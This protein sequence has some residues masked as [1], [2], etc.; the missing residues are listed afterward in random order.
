MSANL[1]FFP[2]SPRSQGNQ[3]RCNMRMTGRPPEKKKR[4]KEI[5][6][7]GFVGGSCL[8]TKQNLY[9]IFF[10]Q[11]PERLGGRKVLLQK[12]FN[13]VWS[14][15]RHVKRVL[16][17]LPL[18]LILHNKT[19][20][21]KCQCLTIEKSQGHA[22]IMKRIWTKVYIL[23]GNNINF[24]LCGKIYVLSIKIVT[25]WIFISRHYILSLIYI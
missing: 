13:K 2:A 11:Q 14:Q 5:T 1:F 8:I 24:I 3:V 16:F 22:W 6:D 25:F 23:I 19:K 7:W 20:Q 10:F 4:E 18:L 21:T 15:I 12:I 9:W 17:F